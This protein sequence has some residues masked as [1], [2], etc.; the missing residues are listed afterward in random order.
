M[1]IV[2][3]DDTAIQDVELGDDYDVRIRHLEICFV[4]VLLLR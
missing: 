1:D 3:G 4:I 2:F